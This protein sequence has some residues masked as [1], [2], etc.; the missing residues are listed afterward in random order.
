MSR[1]SLP[2]QK[3]RKFD[4]FFFTGGGDGLAA[5]C[6]P[7]RIVPGRTKRTAKVNPAIGQSALYKVAES[8]LNMIVLKRSGLSGGLVEQASSG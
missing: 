2:S 4:S 3:L 1:T 6:S 5:N 7:A 8:R